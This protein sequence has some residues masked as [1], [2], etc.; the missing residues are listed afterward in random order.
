MLDG[1]KT[2]KRRQ[3]HGSCSTT[4]WL[5]SDEKNLQLQQGTSNTMLGS[6]RASVEEIVLLNYSLIFDGCKIWLVSFFLRYA[7]CIECC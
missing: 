6:S 2:L 7:P 3:N 4:R 1:T 5:H